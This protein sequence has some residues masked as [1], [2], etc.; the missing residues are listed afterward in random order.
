MRTATYQETYGELTRLI[1]YRDGWVWYGVLLA[2]LIA[3]PLL[4][5]T[6]IAT[7]ATLVFI[8]AVGAIGLNLVTGTTGLISLG[9]AG[10]LAIG[11]YTTAILTSKYNVELA[12]A[13][14]ASGAMAAAFSALVGI[15]SLRLK[16]LYL[17]V[18]TLAFSIIVTNIILQA[19][20]LTGGSGGISVKRTSLLGLPID[21]PTAVYYLC[22]GTLVLS[23]L[24]ALNL[25]RSRVGR[26]WSSIRDYDIAAILM[27]INLVYYKLLAFAVSA[28]LTGV[29]G[30]LLAIHI[31]YVNIDAFGVLT[32]VEALAMI[33][34]GGLASV[35]GAVLGAF[36]ITILPDLSRLVFSVAGASLAGL[37][38][39]H[40]QELRAVIYAL[41]IMGF[42]RFEPE[43][44][45][46]QWT[47]TKRYWSEWPL[48]KRSS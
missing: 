11:A 20:S 27:G 13:I 32:S 26:A 15:P 35:R 38:A 22:L 34:V 47:R 23:V 19:E 2:A 8:A 46:A 40:A 25:L 5:P 4:L 17:A 12:T 33:I 14:I 31:R 43:G 16:G 7:Y 45:A 41:L 10:F 29:A 48:T 21:T 37:S 18:T 3:L 36:L 44:L 28:F 42:L 6:Y 24:G 1:P 9:H 30:A 39:A